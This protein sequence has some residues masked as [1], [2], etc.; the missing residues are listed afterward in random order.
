MTRRTPLVTHDPD[1]MQ[2]RSSPYIRRELETFRRHLSFVDHYADSAHCTNHL[3]QHRLCKVPLQ[4]F[5]D[6]VTQITF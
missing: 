2:R 6:G 5:R 1:D 3:L 4:R